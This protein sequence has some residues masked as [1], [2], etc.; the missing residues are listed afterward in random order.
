MN[1]GNTNEDSVFNKWCWNNWTSTCRSESRHR[2]YIYQKNEL[3]TDHI[4]KCKIKNEIKNLKIK[5]KIPKR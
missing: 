1:K 3:V 5:Y 4:P 2:P